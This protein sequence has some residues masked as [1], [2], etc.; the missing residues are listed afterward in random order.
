MSNNGRKHDLITIPDS[1]SSIFEKTDAALRRRL[2]RAIVDRHPPT[3]RGIF[4]RF[5]LAALRLSFTAFY[6]CKIANQIA[7]LR[8]ADLHEIR[9][10]TAAAI[11]RLNADLDK[12]DHKSE[13]DD[14]DDE[15]DDDR[16]LDDTDDVGESSPQG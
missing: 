8:A 14:F 16:D 12:E 7:T 4:D 15:P 13:H 1:K 2:N 10:R 11:D 6:L 5:N 3:Y 9:Q